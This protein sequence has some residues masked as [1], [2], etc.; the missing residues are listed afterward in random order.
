M[1]AW[2]KI[3]IKFPALSSLFTPAS[4][5]N[6]VK[7]RLLIV[8]ARRLH[9]PIVD[10]PVPSV[11]AVLYEYRDRCGARDTMQEDNH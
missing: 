7:H 4:S 2:K 3:V 10:L 11:P 8:G 9:R 6:V 1:Y 5:R